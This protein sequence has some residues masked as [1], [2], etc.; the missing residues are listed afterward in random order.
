[1]HWPT[2]P[3]AAGEIRAAAREAMTELKALGVTLAAGPTAAGGFHVYARLPLP[4]D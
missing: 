1:M 4:E 2:I 3:L